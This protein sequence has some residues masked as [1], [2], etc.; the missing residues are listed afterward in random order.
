MA[1]IELAA[2]AVEDLTR[3]TAVLSLPDDTTDRVRRSLQPLADF[4]L[5]GPEMGGRWTPLRFLLGPW[6]WML[7]LYTYGEDADRV[8]IVTIQDARSADVATSSRDIGSG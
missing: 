4:P 5:L 8:V 6:R 3:L 7:I 2:A 1:R